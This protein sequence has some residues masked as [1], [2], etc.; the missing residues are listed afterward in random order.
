M[1][2]MTRPIGWCAAALLATVATAGDVTAQDAALLQPTWTYASGTAGWIPDTVSIGAQGQRVFSATGTFGASARLFSA[3]A[4]PIATDEHDELGYRHRVDSSEATGRRVWLHYRSA[5]ASAPAYPELRAYDADSAAPD[6]TYTFPFSVNQPLGGVGISEDGARTCAWVY[7]ASTLSTVVAVFNGTASTPGVYTQVPTF[8]EPS[9]ARLSADATRLYLVTGPKTFVV[10]TGSGNVVQTLYNFHT[11]GSAHALS[12]DGDAYAQATAT[13]E[14]KLYRWQGAQYTSTYTLDVAGAYACSAAA[15]SGDGRYLAAT[16]D[17][18]QDE[19]IKLVVVDLTGSQP[20]EVYSHEVVGSGSLD[21]STADLVV[22]RDGSR[23]V[24]GN[25]GDGAGGVPEV[26][27][28]GRS[29]D[30]WSLTHAVD[31]PGSVR[32]LDLD[33]AGEHLAV[34]SKT[35]HA[36]ALGGGGRYDHVE[37]PPATGM[38]LVGTPRV[39]TTVEVRV[40]CGAGDVGMLL[41]SD[42]LAATPADYPGIGRLFLSRGGMTSLARGADSGGGELVFQLDL[43]G[44]SVG[45]AIYLQGLVFGPRRL[46]PGALEVVVQP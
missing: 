36:T 16:F 33:A 42:A 17:G 41:A 30:A 10:D 44:A 9:S 32:D 25:W 29:G 2:Q 37:L 28:H 11:V 24:V 7:D 38:R 22:S 20:V 5:T 1:N 23:V 6:F 27:V 45:D 40:S 12:P 4:T 18:Y 19:R 3:S 14:L 8:L 26:M 35:A 13:N 39:G 34:A 21:L 43:S 31:L 46:S 15:F